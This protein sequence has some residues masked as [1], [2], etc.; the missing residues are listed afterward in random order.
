MKTS[1]ATQMIS[2]Y[3]PTPTASYIY[4]TFPPEFEIPEYLYNNHTNLNNKGYIAED[5]D[6]I[7]YCNV[8]DKN[9]LYRINKQ[10]YEKEKIKDAIYERLSYINISD[11]NIYFLSGDSEKI[12]E[13]TSL[14][15]YSINKQ[16]G[17]QEKLVTG[18][19]S[20]CLFDYGS[21]YYVSWSKNN[22]GNQVSVLTKVDI[23]SNNAIVLSTAEQSISQININ[24]DSSK[25]YYYKI[26]VD[27]NNVCEYD[28]N[29]QTEKVILTSRS[30]D[31]ILKAAVGNMNYYQGSI[32][33]SGATNSGGSGIFRYDIAADHIEL[34]SECP[35]YPHA[36]VLQIAVSKSGIYYILNSYETNTSPRRN[37]LFRADGI[38]PTLITDLTETTTRP[39]LNIADHLL[40][41]FYSNKIETYN[42]EGNIIKYLNH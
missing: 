36:S 35:S 41:I 24:E 34:I 39:T 20:G 38:K 8:Y 23:A 4:K 1:N 29:K 16:G 22:V 3:Y 18:L 6:F 12:S 26:G 42:E 2:N 37:M 15:L 7:Y 13:D 28:L 5:S 19:P 21:I 40:F 10:T 9:S 17:N 25:L 27:G 30:S 32:Y 33:Y 14:A 31:T 11:D